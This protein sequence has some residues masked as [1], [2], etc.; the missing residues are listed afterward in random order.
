MKLRNPPRYGAIPMYQLIGSVVQGDNSAPAPG[1]LQ[2]TRE[3]IRHAR[4]AAKALRKRMGMAFA[5]DPIAT[6]ESQ[7]EE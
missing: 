3:E 7:D 2:G 6:E 4:K 5:P 1:P